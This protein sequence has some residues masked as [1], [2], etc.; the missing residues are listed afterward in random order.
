MDL[1]LGFSSVTSFATGREAH[2]GERCQC[3]SSKKNRGAPEK[4]TTGFIPFT[5]TSRF[6]N[7]V[8]KCLKDDVLFGMKMMVG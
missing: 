7:I 5:L 3:S 6:P 2:A 8:L 1:S 4:L